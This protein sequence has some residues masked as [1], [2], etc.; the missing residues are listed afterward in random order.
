MFC[1]APAPF[2][3]QKQWFAT[4]LCSPLHVKLATGRQIVLHVE[5]SGVLRRQKEISCIHSCPVRDVSFTESYL[6]RE[7]CCFR[8]RNNQVNSVVTPLGRLS[9]SSESATA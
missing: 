1:P 3:L 7:C 5:S 4:C 8:S 9:E 2:L 6:G